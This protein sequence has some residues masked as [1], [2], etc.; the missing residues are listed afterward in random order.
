MIAE[1]LVLTC[2]DQTEAPPYILLESLCEKTMTREKFQIE[3]GDRR[4]DG[5]LHLCETKAP[6]VITCHGLFSS[7]Q[8]DK[9][10]QIADA[11]LQ[12]GFAVVRFDFGGCGESTG[13]IADT[14]VTRR[15]QELDAVM[16]HLS[17]HEKLSGRY[18]ILGSSLGGY[19]GLLYAARHPAVAALSVWA[20]PYDLLSISKN[21]P[22]E[23]L[24]KLK[25]EFF[26]DAGTYNLTAAVSG[27]Q[28]VQ[29][30][31]GRQ[32][33]I[34]PWRHAERLHKDLN[35]PKELIFLPGADHSISQPQQRGQAITHSL[36]W[37][38][39]RLL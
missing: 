34:V 39:R 16:R 6:A 32:D 7:K 30:I 17:G 27:M 11:F 3:L 12:K 35:D 28:S 18:G 23:D 2:I 38:K 1:A 5:V 31:H 19:V 24:K 4:I 22:R 26:S 15:L 14:T 8:S 20:T 9:F 37:F 10:L 29:V 21:I 36:A 33:E 13:D 25:Q